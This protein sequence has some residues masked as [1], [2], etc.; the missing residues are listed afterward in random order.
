MREIALEIFRN[1]GESLEIN[2][3][4]GLPWARFDAGSTNFVG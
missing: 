4:Y 3:R 1:F 2:S